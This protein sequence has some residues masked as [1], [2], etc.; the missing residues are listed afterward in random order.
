MVQPRRAQWIPVGVI[1]LAVVLDL[2]TPPDVT[3]APL[4]MA[5]PVAAAPLLRLRG[6]IAIGVLAMAVHAVLAWV[7][8][9]FGWKRGVANQLTLMA[10]TVL[11]VLINR[12][13]EGQH[14]RTRRARHIAAVAQ[15]AVLPRPPSRLGELRIAARYVPAENEATIGGDLYVVQ[16]TPHGVRVMVGDV[17][18]KGLGAVSAVCADLGAFR[19]AADE[20]EDLPGL[21]SSLERALLREGR[22]RG[23]QEEDEGFTT[24]L[25]AEFAAGLDTVRVVNR[26]HPPPVLLDA[27]GRATV[28]EPSEEAPPLGMSALGSWS[29]PVDT[30]PFPPGATLVCYTDGVTEARDESGVF[31]DAAVRLPLLIRHRALTGDPATPAQ[32][33]HLLIE[34]VG[35]H[36][37]GRIQ[38]D[39]ALL[40]LHRPRTRSRA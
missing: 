29:S 7:D 27:E 37:G 20:A 36:T 14:A 34:D 12:A 3:S 15:S 1:V 22:R 10:V 28:L 2:A 40:A 31:Y 11:A 35:H 25:I 9:T 17:R 23:G 5:A 19:Y 26:G 16:D 32:I 38:D 4:L 6:I 33:L 30:F 39:Q 24:A 13:L 18:G 21:V 8:G